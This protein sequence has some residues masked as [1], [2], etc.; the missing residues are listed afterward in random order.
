[1]AVS[2]ASNKAHKKLTALYRFLK[3]I[4]GL[5]VHMQDTRMP[6]KTVHI[7]KTGQKSGISSIHKY[8]SF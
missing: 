4:V 2:I 8:L 5:T 1:M 7:K 6:A 3:A